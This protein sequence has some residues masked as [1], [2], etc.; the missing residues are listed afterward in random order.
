MT[1]NAAEEFAPSMVVFALDRISSELTECVPPVWGI[2]RSKCGWMTAETFYEYITNV[3]NPWLE[4]TKISKPVVL[5]L[6]G[7]SS[8][9]SLHLSVFCKE[10]Q[11]VL[12]SLYP[13]TTHICQLLD[14]SVFKP[15]KSKWRDAVAEFR[16]QKFGKKL[17]RCDF[18]FLLYATIQKLTVETLVNG[19]KHC[20][21]YPFTS[22]VVPSLFERKKKKKNANNS[23]DELQT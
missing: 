14:V 12:I 22:A 5:F 7:H 4:E 2:G 1:I 9:L 16:S 23:N 8:H 17:T 19:F 10:Q 3:F 13:N 15:L 21:L 18:S 6:D 20:G 11:I